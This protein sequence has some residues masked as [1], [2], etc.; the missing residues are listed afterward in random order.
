MKKK[1]YSA[2]AFLGVIAVAIVPFFDLWALSV[3]ANVVDATKFKMFEGVPQL[4]LNVYEYHGE[5][6]Q[7]VWAL[8]VAVLTSLFL[9]ASLFFIV[10]TVLKWCKV[11]KVDANLVTRI[12]AAAMAISFVLMF[13][14]ATVFTIVNWV[15]VAELLTVTTLN[16]NGLWPLYMLFGGGLVAS[17]FALLSWERKNKEIK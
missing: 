2:I 4:I 7:S 11:K 10:F 9:L 12:S 6:F 8:L 16:I 5:P 1:L 13:A 17:V 3:N 15:D 14:S